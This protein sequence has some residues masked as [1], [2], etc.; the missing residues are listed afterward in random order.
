MVWENKCDRWLFRSS[1]LTSVCEGPS[2]LNDSSSE[3]SVS[4]FSGTGTTVAPI[5]ISQFCFFDSAQLPSCAN[6]P[7]KMLNLPYQVLG[8]PAIECT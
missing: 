1:V 5:S 2:L 6:F 8:L 3:E 7:I 4:G